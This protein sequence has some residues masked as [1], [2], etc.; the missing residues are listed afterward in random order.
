M[1]NGISRVEERMSQPSTDRILLPDPISLHLLRIVSSRQCAG[2]RP[3]CKIQPIG[4]LSRS[5]TSLNGFERRCV[6]NMGNKTKYPLNQINI[7]AGVFSP[8]RLLLLQL[9]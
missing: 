7:L 1:Y 5:R 9:F 8:K 3:T 2:D 6:C 4:T